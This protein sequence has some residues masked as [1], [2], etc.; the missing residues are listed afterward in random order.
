MINIKFTSVGQMTALIKDIKNPVVVNI[1][2]PL[3]IISHIGLIGPKGDAGD[4]LNSS[5]N[6]LAD[7]QLTSPQSD[8]ILIYNNS[9]F[10]NQPAVTLTDGGN[11]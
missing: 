5:I 6:D 4:L 2:K 10:I 9:K 11:F 7:V 3:S 8:D 1:G